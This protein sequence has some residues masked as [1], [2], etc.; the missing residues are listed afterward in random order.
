MVTV[1]DDLPAVLLR[2]AGPKL[3]AGS[4]E[5]A[6]LLLGERSAV[7][8]FGHTVNCTYCGSLSRYVVF[9]ANKL[10]VFRRP[11]WP[12]CGAF[13]SKATTKRAGG[14]PPL[15]RASFFK[16]GTWNTGMLA[17]P[18]KTSVDGIDWP[19]VPGQRG[20]ALL[21]ILF[22]LEQSQWWTAERILDRQF[23]QLQLLLEH[24]PTKLNHLTG[25]ILCRG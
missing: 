17:P 7:V 21:A 14:I 16:H 1:C 12:R 23:R 3:T 6:R 2:Q 20:S 24:Y 5:A 9:R 11:R 10:G 4:R 25:M 18:L 22:Q 13:G 19:A 15:P 8:P